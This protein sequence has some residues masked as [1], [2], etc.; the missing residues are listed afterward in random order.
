MMKFAVPVLSLFL[1][2]NSSQA[3]TNQPTQAQ[4]S[5][6]PSTSLSQTPTKS[7][8]VIA[9]KKAQRRLLVINDLDDSNN[10]PPGADELDL[11]RAYRRP[12]LVEDNDTDDLSDYV[13][14]RLMVARAK[15]MKKYY[16]TQA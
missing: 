12:E 10:E 16:E 15:A 13:K 11:H 5:R 6:K 9:A 2:L 7:V 3:K 4:V 14:I 1:V 8:R